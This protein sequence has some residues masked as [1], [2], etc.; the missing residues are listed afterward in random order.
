LVA[1]AES[2]FSD[3]R[4]ASARIS[5]TE[6]VAAARKSSPELKVR[7]LVIL[8][9]VELASEEFAAA[10]KTFERALAIAPHHP[11]ARRGKELAQ[12]GAASADRVPQ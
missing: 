8:G 11:V 6:A 12:E 7:A 2:A 1:K 4:L 10:V 5:A 3:G 9:K